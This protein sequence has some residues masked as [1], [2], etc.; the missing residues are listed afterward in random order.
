MLP[1][2]APAYQ[3]T[4]EKYLFLQTRHFFMTKI[5][6]YIAVAWR[7]NFERFDPRVSHNYFYTQLLQNSIT[8]LLRSLS[9]YAETMR[10]VLTPRV[11]HARNRVGKHTR[12]KR[13]DDCSRE[14]ANVQA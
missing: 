1:I 7:G 3:R 10:A 6:I 5:R 14:F 13:R 9:H 11:R 8:R 12:V 4:A 2:E